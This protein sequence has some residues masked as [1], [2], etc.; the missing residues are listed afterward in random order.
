M[1]SLTVATTPPDVYSFALGTPAGLSC[2]GTPGAT[3]HIPVRAANITTHFAVSAGVRIIM[4][5]SQAAA[6]TRRL[7]NAM[8]SVEKG[9]FKRRP[10]QGLIG[11]TF[12][13]TTFFLTISLRIGIL[14]VGFCH[15]ATCSF[16]RPPTFAC[17]PQVEA[18][19]KVGNC[20]V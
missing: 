19:S 15:F 18:F 5:N 7:L 6:E 16:W 1:T 10:D 9:K 17:R 8:V 4:D 13:F 3:A 11:K 12:T 2:I 20:I 14:K